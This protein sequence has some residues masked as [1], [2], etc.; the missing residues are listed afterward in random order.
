MLGPFVSVWP[1]PSVLVTLVV[2]TTELMTTVGKLDV[3]E[4]IS[5]LIKAEAFDVTVTVTGGGA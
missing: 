1:E 2:M 3:A 5:P 4:P